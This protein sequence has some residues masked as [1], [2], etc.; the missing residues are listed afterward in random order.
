ME[1]EPSRAI[2]VR[3]ICCR[4]YSS[5]SISLCCASSPLAAG[6]GAQRPFVS[7]VG[8]AGIC[9]CIFVVHHEHLV[10]VDLLQITAQVALLH[11]PSIL[12]VF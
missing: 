10:F 3:P 11:C 2:P 7:F 9:F 1:I 4:R 12:I 8:I 5:Y 6:I